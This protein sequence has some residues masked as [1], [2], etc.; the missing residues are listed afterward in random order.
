ML[1]RGFPI[2]YLAQIKTKEKSS[3]KLA[4]EHKGANGEDQIQ[5]VDSV[6]NVDAFNQQSEVSHHF[7]SSKDATK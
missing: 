6:Q 5:H 3:F 1:S 4:L 2:R 7:H